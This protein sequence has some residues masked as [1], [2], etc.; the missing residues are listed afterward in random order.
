MSKQVPPDMPFV[1]IVIIMITITI[2]IIIIMEKKKQ[3]KR[4]VWKRNKGK[5]HMHWVRLGKAV[6]PRGW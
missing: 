3:G 2:M 1:C 4:M 5:R 6:R